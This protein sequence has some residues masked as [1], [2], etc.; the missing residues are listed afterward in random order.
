MKKSSVNLTN[1]VIF[2]R[3]LK[4]KEPLPA[5]LVQP[6]GSGKL[7]WLLDEDVASSLQ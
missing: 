3:I 4:D 1:L 6:S 7:I 5:A 2:Q